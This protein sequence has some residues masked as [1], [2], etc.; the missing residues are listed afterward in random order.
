[1][2][3]PPERDRKEEAKRT[4]AECLGPNG[5]YASSG[6]YFGQYFLRDISL[7]S[8]A[9]LGL[10]YN[11]LLS[12]SAVTFAKHQRE[13]GDIPPRI[14]ELSKLPAILARL[15]LNPPFI[16]LGVFPPGA[17][18]TSDSTLHFVLSRTWS[19]TPGFDAS[20]AK[21]VAYLKGAARDAGGKLVGPDW[22]DSMHNLAGKAT[23][24]NQV[25]LLRAAELMGDS[26]WADEL[27]LTIERGFWSD[28]LGY[29]MDYEGS[30]AF[31]VFGHSLAILQNLIPEQRMGSVLQGLG[32]SL[33]VHGY[34][35]LWPC[36]EKRACGQD[37]GTYQNGSVW[38][39]IQGYAILA[40]RSLGHAEQ[41][42]D[43]LERMK[44][45]TGFN[46]WYDP[47]TGAPR[48]SRGQLWSAA[49]YLEAVQ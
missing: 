26:A 17:L 22:R 48:G 2:A 45:L 41:A 46:E 49:M 33:S 11:D 30:R 18:R 38:P 28:G 47:A 40:L 34:R 19:R 27:R 7:S 12:A 36:Y 21:A 13:R 29:Y 31:D 37:P 1:L 15:V 4:I 42:A 39:L 43:E 6:T 20:V 32:S 24:C 3:L 23:F 8:E 44:S 14:I 35:N 5:F 10:G 25:L 9:L 16:D